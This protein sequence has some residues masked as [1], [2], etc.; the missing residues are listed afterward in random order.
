M[1][2][3]WQVLN[4]AGYDLHFRKDNSGYSVESDLEAAR[5]IEGKLIRW[6]H[7]QLRRK[8]W[9]WLVA[10]GVMKNGQI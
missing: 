6:L 9:L 10:I 3:H 2:I 8:R 4:Q 1:E 5:V 7:Q